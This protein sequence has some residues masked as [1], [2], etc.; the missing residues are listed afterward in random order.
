MAQGYV[1][2]LITAQEDGTPHTAASSVSVIP[3]SAVFTLPA[4]FF[5]NIGQQLIIEAAGRISSVITTPGVCRF[6]VRLGGTVVFDGLAV[7][8]DTVAAHTD[9]GWKL[10]IVLTCREIGPTANLM[11]EGTFVCEDILGTPAGAPKGSLTAMLPWNSAPAVG[12]NF[13]STVANPVDLFHTQTV[14]SGSITVHQFSLTSP[15]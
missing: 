11:G 2:T 10:R 3:P 1:E 8:L 14:T 9:V 12:N 13:D 5:R 15:N 6:D 7:L 4:N